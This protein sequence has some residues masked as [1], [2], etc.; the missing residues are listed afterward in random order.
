M[1][2][3]IAAFDDGS[4]IIEKNQVPNMAPDA[5]WIDAIGSFDMAVDY[6]PE[7]EHYE[8]PS[9]STFLHANMP[10]VVTT[11][12]SRNDYPALADVRYW[13]NPYYEGQIMNNDDYLG[14]NHTYV[15]N[16][17]RG[18]GQYDYPGMM[19]IESYKVVTRR[20]NSISYTDFVDQSELY[21]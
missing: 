15:D 9:Q 6:E 10:D 1:L 18:S 13:E 5:A 20:G 7:L 19:P 17:M 2:G 14:G 12:N 16:P 4:A 3:L 11:A 8:K 21:S